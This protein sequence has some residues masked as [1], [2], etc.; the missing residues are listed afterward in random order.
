MHH[1]SSERTVNFCLVD[2]FGHLKLHIIH[3]QTD[4]RSIRAFCY[5]HSTIFGHI[6]RI[7]LCISVDIK[8]I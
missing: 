7:Q 8:S 4:F 1:L 3:F 2:Q 6:V 5:S